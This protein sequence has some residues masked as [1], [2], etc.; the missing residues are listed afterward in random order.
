[1]LVFHAIVNTFTSKRFVEPLVK[2]EQL[3][4][5]DSQLIIDPIGGENK[6]LKEL[7]VRYKILSF[8]F[9]LNPVFFFLRL[10]NL[11]KFILLNKPDVIVCHMTKG[12]FIPL[13]ASHLCRVNKRIYYNHG[14][15]YPAYNGF[16]RFVLKTIERINC[17]NSTEI[18]TV[19]ESLN[20]YIRPLTKKNISSSIPGSVS[21]VPKEFHDF[22]Y[23]YDN[24][25]NDFN[26]TEGC[27]TFLYVGR[28][29]KRKGFHLLLDCFSKKEHRNDFILLIA[30]CTQKDIDDYFGRNIKNVIA[31]GVI[32]DLR[33]LYEMSDFI[34][35][36]SYHEG[37]GLS[38]IE[39]M[40]LGCVPIVSSIKELDLVCEGITSFRF[41][42]NLDDF[43]VAIEKALVLESDQ[44][45]IFKEEAIGSSKKYSEEI[46]TNNYIRIL[47][48]S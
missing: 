7:T 9:T 24:F 4:G 17:F 44:L 28:P 46:V 48:E 11:V 35:L 1:M 10:F 2:A 43:E 21:G 18:M 3:R 14:V 26:I 40:T 45:N 33:P 22:N 34:L 13:I 31:L 32:L 36:P 16:M 6:F 15:P 29:H 20:D 23:S 12:A 39:G 37:F 41:D 19:N 8:D 25:L 30:G 38:I 42:L 5:L 27:K 47:Y